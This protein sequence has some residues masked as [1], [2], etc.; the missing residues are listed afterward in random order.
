MFRQESS[1][2]GEAGGSVGRPWCRAEPA[3]PITTLVSTASWILHPA[4]LSGV[5]V[6]Q[7][8]RIQGGGQGGK[9]LAWHSLTNGL[10]VSS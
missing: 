10:L 9:H 5:V 1:K 3:L 6:T 7:S 2:G 8:W 4:S